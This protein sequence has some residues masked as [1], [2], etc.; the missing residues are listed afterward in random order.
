MNEHIKNLLIMERMRIGLMGFGEIPRHIYRLCLKRKDIEIVAISEIGK[1]EI[2]HYLVEAEAKGK[3]NV[4]LDGNFLVSENGRAR[5]LHGVAP[6]DVPWDIFNVDFVVDGTWKYRKKS[7]MQKHIDSGAKRVIL[8]SLP[9]DE[10]DRIVIKG[11]NED[12]ISESDR[13][14]SPGSAT[15]NATAIMLGILDKNFGV[16]AAMLSTV[17]SYTSEQP[18]RDKAGSDYRK[19]RSAA[20]NIIPIETPIIEWI[21]HVLPEF[22]DKIE[23]FAINV[24]VPNGSLLDLTTILKNGNVGLD[25]VLEAVEKEAQ[26]I[27]EIIQVAGDPVVSSDIIGKKQSVVYDK[28]AAIK[29]ASRMI[30]T[31]AWYHAALAMASRI[32]DIISDYKKLSEKGGK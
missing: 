18:L 5:M 4:E 27:P 3:V 22:K 11:V 28:I 17:H 31:L 21:G 1:N 6:G 25:D 20:E 26:K 29:S 30:K 2:F 14:I 12:T 16:D 15:I 13:L 7:D 19:S 10:I 23:G 8:S 9:I 24:P 32:I